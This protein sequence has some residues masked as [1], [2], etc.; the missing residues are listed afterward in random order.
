MSLLKKAAGFIFGSSKTTDDIFDKD[1]GILV[2]AGGFLNDLHHSGQEI[3]KEQQVLIDGVQ[4]F[5]VAT[6]NEN[7]DRSKTRRELAQMWFKMQLQLIGLQVLFF[8]IDKFNLAMKFPDLSLSKDFADIAFSALIWAVT[9][10]IGVFFWGSHVLRS[11]K[12]AK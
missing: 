3:A 7:T 2:K 12:F 8:C 6:L 5:A 4:A 10:G 9:S 1:S 11:S